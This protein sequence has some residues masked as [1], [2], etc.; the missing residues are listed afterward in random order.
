MTNILESKILWTFRYTWQQLD[1]TDMLNLTIDCDCI[2]RFT[3]L[4]D[5][6][7]I[8]SFDTKY[9]LSANLCISCGVF[10]LGDLVFGKRKFV[11]ICE[12]VKKKKPNKNKN[13]QTNKQ[14]P[15]QTN[16]QANKQ[17]H[18]QT[19][20]CEYLEVSSFVHSPFLPSQLSTFCIC[21][22]IKLHEW[23]GQTLK[24]PNCLTSPLL[25][26]HTQASPSLTKRLCT[27]SRG[28]SGQIRLL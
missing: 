2:W 22:S 17:T 14:T 25:L 26:W 1:T 11:S 19:K 24:S 12:A 4:T 13:K 5:T 23:T 21:K 27:I 20:K 8:F 9:V 18:T 28:S 3:W 6:W 15:Q 10:S 7:N 16:K